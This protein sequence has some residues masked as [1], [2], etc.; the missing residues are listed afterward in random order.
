MAEFL[1]VQVTV[2]NPPRGDGTQGDG[3]FYAQSMRASFSWGSAPG[4][5]TMV[6]V[7]SAP[8]TRGAQMLLRIG[9]MFF[10]GICRSDKSRRGTSGNT[11]TLEFVDFREYLTWDYIWCC[12]NKEDIRSVNGIRQKRYWHILPNNFGTRLKTWTTTPLLGYQILSYI[13]NGPTIGTPWTWD[14]TSGGLFPIGVLNV[15]VFDFEAMG[16]KRLDAALNEIASATGTVF[17]ALSAPTN[18]YQLQ[19]TRKGYGPLPEFLPNDD[20]REYGTALSGN[21]TNVR[22][23][24]DRNRYQVMDVP[25]VKDWAAAWEQFLALELFADDIFL[26]ATDPATGIRYNAIPGD[27][28]QFVGRNLAL[29]RALR[30]TVREY[31]QLR[32]D[33]SF[34][35]YRKFAGRTRMD[36]PAALYLQTLV[37]RAFKPQMTGLTNYAGEFVPLASLD[38]LDQMVCRVAHDLTTGVM[39]TYPNEP[40][41]SNGYAITKGYQVGEELFKHL[42]PDQFDINVFANTSPTRLWQTAGYQIDDS[43]EGDRFIIFDAP[44]FVSDNL[45]VQVDGLAVVNAGFTLQTPDTR[46]ALVFAAENFSRWYGTYPSISR[47]TVANEPSLRAE[48]VLQNGIYTEVV[49]WD[50][51]S[52]ADKAYQIGNAALSRQYVYATGGP[53]KRIW[54][55]TQPASSFTMALTSMVDRIEITTSPAGTWLVPDL[56]T[57]RGPDH[58]QP[59]RDQDRRSLESSLFPGQQELIR[60]SEAAGRLAQGFRQLPKN[61]TGLLTRFLRGETS[62]APLLTV[63]IPG[64]T[65]TLPAGTPI[66]KAATTPG[67]QNTNTVAVMPAAVGASHKVF[68]GVTVRHNE[69]VTRPFAVQPQGPAVARVQGPVAPGDSIGWAQGQNYLVSS[70]DPAV[71]KAMQAIAGTEVKLIQVLLGSGGGGSGLPVWL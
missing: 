40:A 63:A 55:P 58:F 19:F 22:V 33:N 27:T 36:M 65:G 52:A 44:V 16:G 13:L 5:A 7:G 41:D 8:V 18:L 39:T 26:R 17:T 35:D 1:P 56:T 9:G 2:S 34:A 10:G 38:L 68:C 57:E 28:E 46:A 12:F 6:Y 70:S 49:Y 23:L 62:D 4:T 67:A 64:G 48:Y 32:G 15:P 20:E 29:E 42:K 25:L 50:G 43:G 24:G 59:E 54:N 30:M 11:R 69:P 71:G 31:V 37:F 53:G 60:Q 21:P 61:L 66:W 47:D 3:E 14:L 51:L 45:M